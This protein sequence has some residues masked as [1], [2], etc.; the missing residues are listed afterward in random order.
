M[1]EIIEAELL[2]QPECLLGEGIQWREDLSRLFFTDILGA[3]LLSCDAAG[4]ALREWRTPERLGSFAFDPEGAVL[5]AF[6]SGLF[7]WDLESGRI[8]RLTEFEPHLP[9][10]RHNDGRCD[11]QGRFLVGGVDE[12]GLRP[13]SSLTRYDGEGVETLLEGI[14]CSNALAFSPDGTVMYHADTPTRRINAYPYAPGSGALGAARLFAETAT[15]GAA[16]DGACVAADGALWSAEFNGSGV[17]E[18]RPDGARG[19][20]IAV[21]APQTTCCCFGG[22][23]LD[24]LFIITAREHMGPAEIEA[25]PKSGGLF[26]A[27]PGATGLPETRFARPLF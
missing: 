19:R 25:A 7:R 10:T 2:L 14:G 20:R 24:I 8:E 15:A 21:D 11:R 23:D 27:R 26:A 16:P 17:Q 9:S 12:E 18:Y 3:R 13:L 22:P 1:S 5:A 6:E 4:G